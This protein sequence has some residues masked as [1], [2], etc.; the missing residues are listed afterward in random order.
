[1]LEKLKNTFEKENGIVGLLF[2]EVDG[3]K[4]SGLGYDMGTNQLNILTRSIKLLHNNTK[5]YYIS[6]VG[7]NCYWMNYEDEYGPH[8]GLNGT[9][10]FGPHNGGNVNGHYPRHNLY[11]KNYGLEIKDLIFALIPVDD[12]CQPTKNYKKYNEWEE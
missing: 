9:W 10:L 12:I 3:F 11:D 6:K 8:K 5:P 4:P 1:M 7:F 2:K